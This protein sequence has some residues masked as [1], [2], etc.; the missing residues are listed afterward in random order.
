M[1]NLDD[2]KVASYIRLSR[3][4]GDKQESESIGNQRDI[5]KRYMQENNLELVDEYVDDGVSGTTFDRPGFN[6]LIKDIEAGKINMIITKD[7]S[8]LGREYIKLGE[9]MEVYFPEHNIR[10]VAINDGID[11]FKND[12]WSELTPFRGI[13]N[14]SYARDISK[15]VRSVLKE[16]QKKGEYMCTIPPYGYKKDWVQ[17]NHLVIDENVSFIVEKIFQMY[18]DGN[19]I[20]AIKNYLNEQKIQSPSGYAKNEQIIRKWNVVTLEK[21]LKSEVYIGNTVAG[22]RV[23]L[24]YK[25]KKRVEMPKD[26]QIITENTHEAIISK[27]DFKKVQCYLNKKS[28]NKLNKHEY[29]LRGLLTCKTCHSHLEVGAKLKKNGKPV[30]NPI[31]YITCRNSKK[32]MCNPQHLNYN[33]LEEEVFSYL[34]KFIALYSN[35]ENLKK[36]YELY[37]EKSSDLLTKHKKDLQAIEN[38]INNMKN[39]IDILYSD[40]L[41]GIISEDDFVRYSK[42]IKAKQEFLENQK[43]EMCRGDFNR[44]KSAKNKNNK[45]IHKIIQDFLKMEKPD[46]KILYQLIDKIGIDENKNVYITFAFKELEG[47]NQMM[48]YNN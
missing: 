31:P 37:Q 25:T 36:V 19:S 40:R 3:E 47:F 45:E 12:N 48:L 46:K 35:E 27:E 11:T 29:C 8:R 44:P 42:N 33:K 14:D 43:K 9:Y 10:Y 28:I 30:K 18:L 1:Q 20:Y 32:G 23:K 4:D 38:Q 24:S 22:K 5:I 7:Y 2:F 16:K 13:I 15:K 6:R 21:M 26:K 41:N 17:K 39:Q 34:Q